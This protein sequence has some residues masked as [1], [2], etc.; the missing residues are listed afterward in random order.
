MPLLTRT[1]K[2]PD[3]FEHDAFEEERGDLYDQ[4]EELDEV[5]NLFTQTP[6]GLETERLDLL[7]ASGR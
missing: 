2:D 6:W 1:T 5:E 3:D 4:C 7:R